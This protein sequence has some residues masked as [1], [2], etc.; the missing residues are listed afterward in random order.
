MTSVTTKKNR[1]FHTT[2]NGRDHKT[3]GNFIHFIG[4]SKIAYYYKDI[5]GLIRYVLICMKTIYNVWKES[6]TTV[7]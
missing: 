4:C 3:N 1:Y 5:S 7:S 2:S 6:V